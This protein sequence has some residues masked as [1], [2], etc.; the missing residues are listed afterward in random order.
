MRT[1][2]WDVDDVLNSLMR[3]WFEVTWK[4]A[5][6]EC[7]LAYSDIRENPPHRSLGIAKE[8]YLA[9]LDKFRISEEA[10]LLAPNPAIVDW[11]RE[12][13]DAYRHLALTAR[14]LDS[15]PAAA[16]WV[17]RHFG[18][19][20]RCF[21]VVP[22]RS[23]TAAPVYDRNKGEFL[24][25]LGIADYFVDDSEENVALAAEAGVRTVLFPQPWNRANCSVEDVLRAI[26]LRVE[27]EVQA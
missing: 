24:K 17:F 14:P 19:H 8:E 20:F 23:D 15:A 9:S 10:R 18:A 7:T 3:E 6:P 21:G 1:I 4:P 26:E 16:E 13:G 22:S 12:H 5:H 2:V 25:W 27:I 11:F